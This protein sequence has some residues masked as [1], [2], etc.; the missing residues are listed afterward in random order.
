MSTNAKTIE[1]LGFT[2]S[3]QVKAQIKFDDRRLWV[4]DNGDVT[5]DEHAGAYLKSAVTQ[6]PKAISHRTPLGTWDA[7]TINLLGGLPC[8]VCVDWTKLELK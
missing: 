1:T 4:S 3:E 6:K 5:C 7:F 8:S 2:T